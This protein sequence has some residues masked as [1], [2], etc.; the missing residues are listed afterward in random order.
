MQRIR[1]QAAGFG[2]LH[3][4]ARIHHK[5]SFRKI[6]HGR[7]V[8]RDVDHREAMSLLQ[9]PQQLQNLHTHRR[10]QHRYRLISDDHLRFEDHGTSDDDA[11]L[12]PA[13]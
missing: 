6:F 7:K 10:I 3:Q 12:L 4:I 5:D 13:A 9:T 1:Q 11:L 2:F 8:M